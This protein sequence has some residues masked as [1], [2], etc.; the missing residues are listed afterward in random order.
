MHL[1]LLNLGCLLR[2]H[3]RFGRNWFLMVSEEGIE[4]R[5]VGLNV[6]FKLLLLGALRLLCGCQLRACLLLVEQNVDVIDL[7]LVVAATAVKVLHKA[8]VGE[9]G[10]LLVRCD[11]AFEFLLH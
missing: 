11:S 8:V 5:Q 2:L 6:R 7:L 3:D 10:G 9:C 4:C 1:G